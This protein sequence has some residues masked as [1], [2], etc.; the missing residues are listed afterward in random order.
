MNMDLTE[1]VVILDKSGSMGVVRNDAFNGINSFILEQKKLPGEANFT[2][3]LFNSEN[4]YLYS[5]HD[6]KSIH[7]LKE[8]EYVPDGF[9]ALNDAIGKTITNVEK[10]LSAYS[11][12]DRP[13]KVIVAIM[14]DGEEN[15]SHEYTSDHIKQLIERLQSEYK[16][17]FV[18]LGANQDA[19]TA[20]SSRG[21]GK[22]INYKM[23]KTAD[24]YMAVNS[25]TSSYRSTGNLDASIVKNFDSSLNS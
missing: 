23:G 1:I 6:L 11:D 10:R 15:A 20:G 7:P 18:F 21:I 4:T 13:G 2:L 12:N 17:E 14:T 5:G 9:T 24:A 22:S 16:W 25:M 19:F 3:T 8:A